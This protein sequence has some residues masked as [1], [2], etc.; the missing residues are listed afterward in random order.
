MTAMKRAA[1]VTGG[2]SGIGLSICEHLARAGHSVAVADYNG[3]GAEE[4]AGAIR[5]S[6]GQAVAVP[7]D[8][9]D[10]SQVDKA[11]AAARG[12]FGPIGVLV[13]SAAVSRKEPFETI[14]EQS[15]QQV[16]T[17]NLTGTFNCVQAVI[18][19]M[20]EAG[21]GRVVLI[22][23]SSAQRGSP[24][25]THY[26]ASKGGVIAFGKALA[27]EFAKR[28]VTVNNIAPSVID[29][30]M[31]EQQRAAGAVGSAEAMAHGVP[32][33]RM[34]TGDDIAAAC[35]YLVSE[36]ASYVTGQTVSVN[37]GSFVGW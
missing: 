25:M 27:L 18:G 23:S 5:D 32:V 21:W 35:L 8:V 2:A 14:S 16:L 17:V 30:P 19:D 24:G 12:E 11:V 9:S 36:E 15:W 26:A 34:G 33:G 10:R 1:F 31:V 13:T 29:T 22:S 4:A 28:G 7:V 6:G 37:G 20:T 3:D